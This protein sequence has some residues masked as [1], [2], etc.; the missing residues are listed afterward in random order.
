MWR[1]FNFQFWATWQPFLLFAL[2]A[3]TCHSWARWGGEQGV[4]CCVPDPWW[5]WLSRDTG[6]HELGNLECSGPSCDSSVWMESNVTNEISV[7]TCKS[8]SNYSSA[9]QISSN[10]ICALCDAVD[11]TSFCLSF[12]Q[13][14]WNHI[15]Y[16]RKLNVGRG[17]TMF[18]SFGT[19]KVYYS[20]VD[21]YCKP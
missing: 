12:T 1:K 18:L 20:S 15:T 14:W 2:P 7:I 16:L 11:G 8:L 4:L 5:L 13:M 21:I 9:A 17:I 3:E 19:I 10:S 6:Q